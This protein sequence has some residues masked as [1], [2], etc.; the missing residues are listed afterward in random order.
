MEQRIYD[1]VAREI[2][3]GILKP[4]LWT[5]AYTET[6][7]DERRAKAT[8]IRLRANELQAIERERNAAD[9]A[10]ET[11]RKEHKD[12]EER[13]LTQSNARE[14]WSLFILAILII[15]IIF[16]ALGG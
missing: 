12:A 5:R 9:E 7:G 10:E 13:R 14:F 11:L 16:V 3:D 1:L 4:G 15:L 6:D 2:Q 8:Y